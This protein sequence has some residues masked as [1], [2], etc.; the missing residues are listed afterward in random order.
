MKMAF[1]P[2]N[3]LKG[4]PQKN[5]SRVGFFLPNP[6]LVVFL[7]NSQNLRGRTRFRKMVISRKMLFT[8]S[9]VTVRPG[10]R[11]FDKG[12]SAKK[13]PHE[14]VPQK[15]NPTF[16]VKFREVRVPQKKPQIAWGFLRSP[17]PLGFFAGQPEL[18]G[19]NS[20]SKK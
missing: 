9:K 10:S 6:Y 7:Q 19:E 18:K 4:V 12:C 15:K 17:Y 14:S 16:S 1:L 2:G 5:P 8:R 13:K 20:I 11:F 3:L